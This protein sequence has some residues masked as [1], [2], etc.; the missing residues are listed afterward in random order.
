MSNI[1][2]EKYRRIV[3]TTITDESM[4]EQSH[5]PSCDIHNIMRRYEATGYIDHFSQNK[6]FYAD[7]SALPDYKTALDT[8]KSVE[9][10]FQTLPADARAEFENDPQA[11]LE[12]VES[13]GSAL[14]F[15][16]SLK[17]DLPPGVVADALESSPNAQKEP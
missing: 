3:E 9:A 11:F 15:A 10:I 7:V 13:A 5:I 4:T 6:A 12:A 16:E 2:P 1:T 8:V 17:P 14:E